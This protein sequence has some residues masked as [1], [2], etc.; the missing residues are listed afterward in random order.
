MVKKS[1]IWF[2]RF[3]LTAIWLVLI[4]MS[5]TIIGLRYFV[6]P[7]ISKYQPKITQAISNTLG[8]RVTIGSIEA[9]W[10]GL[11]PH[12]R[13]NDVDIYDQENRVALS[14]HKV[15]SAISWLSIPFFEP[16]LASLTIHQPELSIRREED[17]TI[18]VAGISMSGPT[19]AAFPNWLL[20]QSEIS[21]LDAEINWNDAMRKAPEIRLSQLNLKIENP[22]WDAI[23]GHHR[24]ALKAKPSAVS[25]QVVDIR[26]KIFGRDVSQWRE[27]H[28]TLF[29][30]IQQAQLAE[31]K[32]WIDLPVDLQSGF[33][34]TRL[35]VDFDHAAIDRISSD[36]DVKQLST[37]LRFQE[38]VSTFN[39]IAGHITW[40]QKKDGQLLEASNIKLTTPDDLD[41]KKGYFFLRE[42][43]QANQT[44]YEAK[45]NLDELQL[46]TVHKLLPYL[47]LSS[48]LSEKIKQFQPVGKLSNLSLSWQSIGDQLNQYSLKTDFTDL[49][50]EPYEPYDIPGFQHVNGSINLDQKSGTLQLNSEHVVLYMKQV[51]RYGV[52]VDYI[53]GKII[54]RHDRDKFN[55]HLNKLA[56][57]TPHATGEINGYIQHDA[58]TG[59]YFD[60]N[61]TFSHAD[62][63]FTK[64]YLPTILSKETLDWIDTSV[65]NGYAEDVRLTL[66]GSLSDF[67]YVNN[68]N[69][70]FRITAKGHDVTLDYANGWPVIDHIKMNMLF[71]GKRMEL[72]INEGAVLKNKI[73]N[74]KIVIPD[75]IVAENDL[76]VKG[77]ITGSLQDQLQFINN[78]PLAAWSGGFTQGMKANG[79]GK[80]NLEIFM[81]LYHNE[82]TKF[83]G[84]Y[85][86]QN[87]SMVSESMPELTQ[88]NG[89]ILFNENT[90]NTQNLRMNVFDSPAI[91]NITTD[92]SKVIQ[93]SAH[94]KI[95]DAG[96]R[97][98]LG[99]ALPSSVVGSTDWQGR[100]TISDKKTDFS[101]KSNLQGLALQLPAPLNKTASENMPFTLERKQSANN[102]DII[103]FNLG[104]AVAGKF[105]RSLQNGIGKIERGEIGINTTP[106]IPNQKM[107]NLRI[108]SNHLDLDDWLLQFDKTGSNSHS[109]EL[110]FNH[111]DLSADSF[112]LFDKRINNLKMNAQISGNTWMFNLKSDEVTGSMRWVQQGAGK[113]LA[114]LAQLTMPQNTPDKKTH[115]KTIK[116]LDIH[117]PDLEINAENFE[118]NKKKFGRLELSAKEQNGNWMIQK[119][120][121]KNPDGIITA[122][123]QWSNWKTQQ[124]TQMNFNWQISDIGKTFKRLNLG[125]TIK[126]GTAQLNGQLRWA[127]SPHEF[128]IPNLAGN[129]Q[130]EANKGQ[131]LKIEPGVGRLFSVLSLQ[132]LPRRLTLDF[133]DLFSS[134]FVF[135]KISAD[136]SVNRGIMRSDNFKM[137]GPTAGVEIKGETD[138]DKETQHLFVKVKPYITDTLSLAAFAG[139]P[140]VG[141]AAY[142]A[143]KVLKNPLDKIAE[144][145]YE[146]VGTWSNPEELENK[147]NPNQPNG[148]FK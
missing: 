112:D 33:G 109:A 50:L 118:V 17:G 14:L 27:W 24:F 127:G 10:Q 90:L 60:L 146:I 119:L 107:I 23:R 47:P 76:E 115:D 128:D 65:L 96:L 125:D 136:I 36:L 147:N 54:W 3:A 42:K 34:D 43:Q 85:T 2:Y 93:I 148:V 88:I 94:G 5:V 39:H 113:I 64:L 31:I 26:G 68:R 103:Q 73:S 91:V 110:P 141:A 41:M 87:A 86:L 130:V 140:A 80:L 131:I 28:G 1:L 46:E 95:N 138:L 44:R 83:K 59:P 139:G 45:V 37:T 40:E 32:Q 56:L 4:F 102:Q 114:N 67:P 135:D 48:E 142:I 105:L 124:N 81:P 74:T 89:D 100:A 133:K 79:S 77:E 82:N 144:S 122:T 63:R 7:E 55:V 84:K 132:N 19:Q 111:I 21:V 66:K 29:A 129:V 22:A 57:G 51:L 78:S 12:I 134:G 117:Y 38:E 126:G 11:N 35:W 104:S 106:E 25:Q 9:N 92:K 145:E 137:E 52:P 15:D 116:Q 58:K 143:Q 72:F 16:R 69:G 120:A 123:G 18:Y 61:A 97:K 108:V 98:S 53:R 70:L 71:E 6:L 75:L 99:L 49:G 101:V 121:L 8:Q 13:L 62:V 30:D 20:R